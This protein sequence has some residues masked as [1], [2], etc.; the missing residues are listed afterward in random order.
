MT[1][2]VKGFPEETLAVLEEYFRPLGFGIQFPFPDIAEMTNEHVRVSFVLHYGTVGT[3]LA[4]RDLPVRKYSGTELRFANEKPWEPLPSPVLVKEVALADALAVMAPEM[5]EKE[6]NPTPNVADAPLP[7]IRRQCELILSHLSPLLVGKT[8]AWDQVRR[9][10][11]YRRGASRRQDEDDATYIR[12]LAETASEAYNAGE[13]RKAG[14]F[15][16]ALGAASG[17][18]SL[19]DRWRMLQA[20]IRSPVVP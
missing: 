3:F 9:F 20:A 17:R 14:T 1:M 4:P 16:S 2:N 6:R 15:Y 8:E 18:L 10:I 19:K 7:E 5:R 13:Y 12:R 11:Q